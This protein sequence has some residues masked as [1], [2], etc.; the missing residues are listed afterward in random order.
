MVR[1]LRTAF[2]DFSLAADDVIAE[3][4]KVVMRWSGSGTLSAEFMSVPATWKV[5]NFTGI[6]IDRI[7]S[8][9]I[10]EHWEQFDATGMMHQLGVMPT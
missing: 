7:V 2:P 8:G 3:G 4:D 10:V 6:S 1:T 9:K 5:I